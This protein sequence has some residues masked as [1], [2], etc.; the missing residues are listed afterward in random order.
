[1]K[2]TASMPGLKKEAALAAA[3]LVKSGWKVG[4]GTGST[5]AFVIEEL[6]R[7]QREE[8][9]EIECVVTSFSSLL[10]AQKAGLLAHPLQSFER[11]DMSIDGADE[12][13]PALNLIKGG[14]GRPYHGKAGT[15]HVLKTLSS[16]PITLRTFRSS[17]IHSKFRLN[18][19]K[20]QSHMLSL[21]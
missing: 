15:C 21:D 5:T 2:N 17:E 4:L 13:D 9:L 1:M 20:T 10:L 11:L 16:S 3:A 8:G 6:G 14:G 7:R 18:S 12:I 19:S